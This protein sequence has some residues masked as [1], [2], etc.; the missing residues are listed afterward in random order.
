ML[1]ID[2]ML[3]YIITPLL[4][5]IF[6]VGCRQKESSQE[7]MKS[8]LSSLYI[9]MPSG[10]LDSILNDRDHKA[11]ADAVLIDANG[12]TLF[13]GPLKH[14]K[15]RGNSTWNSDKKPFAIKLLRSRELLCLDKSKSFVLLA[16]ALDESH[17]RNAIAFDLAYAIGLPAPK[18]TFTNLYL[19]GAYNGLYQMTNKV[20]I[21]KYSLD[22]MDLEKLNKEANPYQP[23]VYNRYSVGLQNQ[24]IQRKGFLLENSPDDIT[25]GYL[26][27]IIGLKD[28]YDRKDCGFLSSGGELVVIRDPEHASMEEVDYIAD[29]YNQMEDAIMDSL[30][31]NDCTGKHYS[32]YLDVYSFAKCYI[33]NEL[34]MNMDAGKSSFYM[35]KN[36]NDKLMAGPIWDFDRTLNVNFWWA[37]YCSAHEIWAGSKTG[38]KEFQLSGGFFYN[39]LRHEDFKQVVYQEWNDTV[40]PICHQLLEVGNWDSLANYLSYDAERDFI[41]TNNR[42]SDSYSK[43]VRCPLDFLQER[44][45]FL[46]WLW[47]SDGDD[48]ICVADSL[49]GSR[50]H[51]RFINLYYRVGEPIVYPAMKYNYDPI[52]EYY[53]A[54]TD[55]II[56]DGAVLNHPVQL[57]M[58]GREP[59]WIEVQTRRVKKKLAKVFD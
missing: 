5:L 46:D 51:D 8:H 58:R 32:D 49:A 39:L 2:Y 55:S 19:N 33:L 59:T 14:I 10:Q 57:E 6:F 38:Y 3:K 20:E 7:T 50:E 18:Y 12:D 43:A 52:L 13:D 30:G 27:E 16:N 28:R 53:I 4:I 22:I 47:S 40:S 29:Y 11:P 42:Q 23:K 34:L 21:N 26:I 44:V 54:G 36:S 9:T 1:N 31:F 24:I 48:V 37:R 56:P 17:L 25:G 45:E 35:Y 41:L 15:T